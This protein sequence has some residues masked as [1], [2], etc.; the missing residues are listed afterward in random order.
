M[1]I[2]FLFIAAPILPIIFI[3]LVVKLGWW[4]AL[5][6]VILALVAIASGSSIPKNGW[7]TR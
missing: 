6:A 2:V 7:R 5:F 4:L 1:I 3:I